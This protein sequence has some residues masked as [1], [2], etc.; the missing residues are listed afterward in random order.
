MVISLVIIRIVDN[1]ITWL[2]ELNDS[3]IKMT[4]TK[5]LSERRSKRAP[6]SVSSLF[7]LAKY[8]SKKSVNAAIIKIDRAIK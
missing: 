4:V 1:T 2:L 8:P 7:N 5:I 3:H 6:I